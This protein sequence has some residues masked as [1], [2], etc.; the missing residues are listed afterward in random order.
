MTPASSRFVARAFNR[1]VTVARSQDT[2]THQGC[3]A[4][5][6]RHQRVVSASPAPSAHHPR[7]QR[8]TRAISAS[9][10]PSAHRRRGAS[11]SILLGLESF[12]A[13]QQTP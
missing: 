10:G 11:D 3:N 6:Q 7:H 4:D 12:A 2:K 8:I 5:H 9:P 1:L 13:F